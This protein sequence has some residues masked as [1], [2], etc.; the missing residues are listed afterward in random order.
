MTGKEMQVWA[1]MHDYKRDRFGHWIKTTAEGVKLRL[2]I[3]QVA[4]R[5][6]VQVGMLDWQGK[7]VHQWVRRRSGYLRDISEGTDGK[8]TGMTLK[9][10]TAKPPTK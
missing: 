6:E 4:A 7:M 2:V 1:A 9:G 8:L 3:S 10:C 5:I